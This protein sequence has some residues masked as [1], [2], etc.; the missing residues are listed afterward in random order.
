MPLEIKNPELYADRTVQHWHRATFGPLD[1]AIDIDLLGACHAC[2]EPIWLAE[3]ST[4]PNK[5][6]TILRKLAARA[7]LPALLIIHDTFGIVAARF[8]WPF[9]EDID[10]ELALVA[11][12]QEIRSAHIRGQCQTPRL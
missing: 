3:S 5:A 4:N 2:R 1:D 9:Y 7:N 10:S 11:V 12:L 8:V 6:T